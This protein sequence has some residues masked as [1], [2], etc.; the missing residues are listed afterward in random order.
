M[1]SKKGSTSAASAASDPG[2]SL[3]GT[4]DKLILKQ[5]S[6]PLLRNYGREAVVRFL[7]MGAQYES[8]MRDAGNEKYKFSILPHVDPST[9][10]SIAVFELHKEVDTISEDEFKVFL[11]KLTDSPDKMQKLSEILDSVRYNRSVADPTERVFKL[12]SELHENLRY[13]KL[14]GLLKKKKFY[15]KV[16]HRIIEVLTP[17]EV[18]EEVENQLLMV[19]DAKSQDWTVLYN[20]VKNAVVESDKYEVDKKAKSKKSDVVVVVAENNYKNSGFRKRESFTASASASAP[21]YVPASAA[22]SFAK[23]SGDI[24]KRRTCYLCGRRGHIVKDCPEKPSMTETKTRNQTVKVN[25]VSRHKKDKPKGKTVAESSEG[26]S[27]SADESDSSGSSIDMD[28]LKKLNSPRV[29]RLTRKKYEE[30]VLLASSGSHVIAT[31][32][33]SGAEHSV[34]GRNQRQRLQGEQIEQFPAYVK[35]A[36]GSKVRVIGRIM[37]LIK[38]GATEFPADIL[39][40][41]ADMDTLLIG[42]P[43]LKVLGL[44]PFTLFHEKMNLD[45]VQVNL[46]EREQGMFAENS[47][48]VSLNGKDDNQVVDDALLTEQCKKLFPLYLDCSDSET[49]HE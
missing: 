32:F 1:A 48:Y 42:R 23:D 33:D 31:V 8:K 45:E 11:L 13:S 9:L 22:S 5:F 20:I 26:S 41:D 46:I 6:P 44:D 49:S 30:E 21:K 12:F 24:A 14:D 36:N 25:K 19:D 16:E 39:V 28:L 43:E 15:K 17:S 38:I 7:E 4:K 29:R 47:G 37:S 10:R 18:K 3:E 40:I 35:V 2:I 34:A 27:S